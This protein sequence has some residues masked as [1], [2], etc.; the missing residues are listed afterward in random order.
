MSQVWRA[1]LLAAWVGLTGCKASKVP[2]EPE[3]QATQPPQEAPP[4][5]AEEA[6]PS[7]T[8]DSPSDTPSE[9]PPPALPGAPDF[10]ADIWRFPIPRQERPCAPAHT[11]QICSADCFCWEEGLLQGNRVNALWAWAPDHVWAAAGRALLF[12]DGKSWTRAPGLQGEFLGVWGSGP[13]DV[14]AVGYDGRAVHWD[15]TTW[16]QT[17][18]GTTQALWSVW[19]SSAQDVWAVGDTMLHWDGS[20]WQEVAPRPRYWTHLV[21]GTGPHNV[22]V[23]GEDGFIAQWDGSAWIP[24][25]L[26]VARDV[27]LRAL[28][29]VSPGVVYASLAQEVWRFDGQAWSQ[30]GTFGAPGNLISLSARSAEDVWAVWT[31][32]AAH[33]DGARWT[34]HLLPSGAYVSA[35]TVAG[36]ADVWAGGMGGLLLRWDGTRW[37]EVAPASER[38]DLPS[39]WARTAEDIWV[40]G[41]RGLVRRWDGQRWSLTRVD[42]ALSFLGAWGPSADNVWLPGLLTRALYAYPALFHWDGSAVREVTPPGN[43]RVSQV[44]GTGSDDIWMLGST[45]YHWD[46][47]AWSERPLPYPGDP[48]RASGIWGSGPKDVWLW[49]RSGGY[50]RPGLY[51]WEGQSWTPVAPLGQTVG[52]SIDDLW[53]SGPNDIWAMTS[54]G[55]LHYDGQTWRRLFQVK[56]MKRNGRVWGTGPDDVWVNGVFF[57]SGNTELMHWNGREWRPVETGASGGFEAM[58][59]T[60]GQVWGVADEGLL[61]LRPAP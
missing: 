29:A 14:W 52:M 15:G 46:G 56:A 25:P 61:R 50:E 40:V 41:T 43:M 35:A 57:G 54:Q 34:T 31:G 26:P 44:W 23:G 16:I 51:H 2:E 6:P 33:W 55:V 59:G 48:Y 36:A 17:D 3:P 21:T 30:V 7:D 53:G 24:R 27:Y 13:R 22:W 58:G 11:A 19:G 39:V 37:T 20:R 47:K 32:H 49:L 12:W 10:S 8:D 38:H 60:R 45:V 9:V 18:T 28:V 4:S 42:P 1:V 5:D